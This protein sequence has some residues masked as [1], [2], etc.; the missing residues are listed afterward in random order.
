MDI[1]SKAI[2]NVLTYL[3]PG[4]VSAAIVYILTPAT[5]PA[6]FERVV[7]ALIYTIVV[8]ALVVAARVAL[9][10]I[11]RYKAVGIWTT[12]G[13]LMWSLLLALGL[14]LASAWSDNSDA[15]HSLLRK[16][17]ITHQT[18][19][20]SE[21]YGAFAQNRGYV[22]L[23][24]AGQRRLYGWAVEWPSSPERGHFVMAQAEWLTPE[25][26][27]ELTGVRHILVRA[28]DVEIVEMMAIIQGGN[29]NGRSQGADA[30]TEA[31]PKS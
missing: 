28:V 27:V 17:K 3:L 6:P 2:I 23:H 13:A 5:R 15:V 9:L 25:G 4:F 18:S 31:A 19:F 11:G 1:P 8:Q 29:E 16:A 12:D 20:S 7:Q 21:W 24:L 10:W 14:G 26:R 22:V 30:A